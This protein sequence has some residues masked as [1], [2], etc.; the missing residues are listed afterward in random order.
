MLAAGGRW[1]QIDSGGGREGMFKELAER[2]PC[3][4]P[5]DSSVMLEVLAKYDTRP[6][7]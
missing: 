7:G 5:P 2:L 6:A 4:A 3:G 1:L